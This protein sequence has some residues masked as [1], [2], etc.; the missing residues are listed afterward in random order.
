MILIDTEEYKNFSIKV[1]Y[2]KENK[3]FYASSTIGGSV[4]KEFTHCGYLTPT[5]ALE[6]VKNKI[7]SFLSTCPKSYEELAKEITNTLVWTGYEDCYV[8]VQVLEQ[9][10]EAFLKN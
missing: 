6:D 7:D 5:E 9:L 3:A 10:V 1:E 2:S 4:N 8:D